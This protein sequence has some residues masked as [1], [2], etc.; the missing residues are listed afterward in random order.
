MEARQEKINHG[1]ME[2]L[3]V[4]TARAIFFTMFLVFLT[5]G[6]LNFNGISLGTTLY[7]EIAL[8]SILCFRLIIATLGQKPNANRSL[9][10]CLLIASG[11]ILGG[12]FGLFYWS[13]YYEM[14]LFQRMI[15]LLFFVGL[16]AGST[17]SM[18][19]S[20]LAFSTFVL[21]IYL[22]IIGRN[23]LDITHDSKIVA[24]L[25]IIYMGFLCMIYLINR[26]MLK[27]N[28]ELWIK[29]SELNEQLTQ[30]NHRLSIASITDGL[31]NLANRRYFQ[32]RL[33]ADW[34]RAK[35][36]EL[37]MSLLIIDIDYFKAIND[38]YGHLYGDECL[39]EVAKVISE[40]VK[41][42]TDL[43]A[44]YGGDEMVIILYDTPLK[45]T[46]EFAENLQNAINN[47]NIK[48]GYSPIS[49]KLTVTI[50]FANMIPARED[51]FEL[52]F[53][54][55]DKALYEGKLKGRNCIYSYNS[56]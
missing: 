16:T 39:R 4:N 48:N 31:T 45:E 20:P 24:F 12:V 43:A 35:R 51:D 8:F 1:L 55:A 47:L 5:L 25:I 49:D 28:I 29:Q 17:I 18:A 40:T 3:F 56:L 38:H 54:Y 37:P 36:A 42:R 13:F 41:R 34:I 23:F 9:I 7:W 10:Y 14:S 2:H 26:Q 44:R 22:P 11:F 30:F 52:I 21:P 27:T 15:I 53:E 19:A 50:G 6:Y 32:E 46:Q 33:I